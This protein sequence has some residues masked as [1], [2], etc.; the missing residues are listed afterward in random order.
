[1]N[2]DRVDWEALDRMREIFLRS[3]PVREAYWRRESDLASYDHTYAQRIAWKWDA[4]L[5]ELCRL[6]WTPPAGPL[7]DWGCG[8]GVASRCVAEAFGADGFGEARFHD[9]STLAMA[10]AARRFGE[11]FPA[12]RGVAEPTPAG[13]HATLVVSHVLNELHRD[14]LPRLLEAVRAAACVLWV[15]PGTY[16][17]SRGLIALRERLRGEFHLVAPCPH[18]SACGLLAPGR[19]ADWCHFFARPPAAVFADG[20]WVRFA[21]RVG[22]DLRSL[23]YAWLV[24]DRRPAAPWPP[25]RAR[26]LGM[27]EVFKPYVR[28]FA[29]RACGAGPAEIQRRASPAEY[30]RFQEKDWPTEA[31]LPPARPA[32]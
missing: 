8:S 25:E 16:A 18:R 11:R 24:L 6:G 1:M 30:A 7:L 32:V 20:D 29:C 12:V 27:P 2:W 13:G 17:A 15:E 22:V 19:E 9:R 28:V 26:V 21:R 31:V 10:Y 4:A 14:D 3:E 5:A 23:P